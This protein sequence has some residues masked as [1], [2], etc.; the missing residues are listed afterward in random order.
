MV[1]LRDQVLVADTS[2]DS[3]AIEQAA[4]KLRDFVRQHMNTD[5]GQIA[6]QS[7]YNRAVQAAFRQANNDIDSSKYQIATEQ[8]KSVLAVS[9]YQ[10]YAAC[11]ADVVGANGANFKTPELPNPAL[12]YL[13]FA[14]PILSFDVAGVF[15]ILTFVVFFAI[16]IKLLTEVIIYFTLYRRQ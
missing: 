5:T 2:G 7:S 12:F 9:G 6:L 8:C 3:R 15:V 11:V 10:G 1:E 14:A 13:S 4:T 16:F